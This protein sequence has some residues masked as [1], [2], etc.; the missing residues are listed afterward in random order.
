VARKGPCATKGVN[1]VPEV[2]EGV[3]GDG[4]VS[5]VRA[6]Q[7]GLE[8]SDEDVADAAVLRAQVAAPRL[9]RLRRVA[10]TRNTNVLMFFWILRTL[11]GL[12]PLTATTSIVSLMPREIKKT[13]FEGA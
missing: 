7:R 12:N 1:D 2:P 10:A 13:Y 5:A 6:A 3:E 11:F 4:V 8:L 9:R